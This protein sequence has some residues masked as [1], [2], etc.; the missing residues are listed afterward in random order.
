MPCALA[1]DR[2]L[3]HTPCPTPPGSASVRRAS[4]GLRPA[5]LPR[6]SGR[7]PARS[8]HPTLKAKPPTVGRAGGSADWLPHVPPVAA[9]LLAPGAHPPLAARPLFHTDRGNVWEP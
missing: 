1:Q 9:P 8:P 4:R 2:R 6:A 7:W 3:P 5:L